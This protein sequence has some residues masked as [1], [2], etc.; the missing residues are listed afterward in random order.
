MSAGPPRCWGSVPA[1]PRFEGA[2]LQG[3]LI[4]VAAVFISPLGYFAIPLLGGWT[5][6]AAQALF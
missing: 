1:F 5:M 4:A 2:V 6:A 3:G